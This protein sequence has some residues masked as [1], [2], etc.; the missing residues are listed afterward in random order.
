MKQHITVSKTHPITQARRRFDIVDETYLCPWTSKARA[1]RAAYDFESIRQERSGRYAGGWRYPGVGASRRLGE[2]G[3][4]STIV[5]LQNG[6]GR[7]HGATRVPDA[8]A[9]LDQMGAS[10]KRR[11]GSENPTEMK[12]RKGGT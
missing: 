1:F 12:V 7:R 10:Q 9:Q 6:H 4:K 2:N 8:D 3:E 11:L 5:Y